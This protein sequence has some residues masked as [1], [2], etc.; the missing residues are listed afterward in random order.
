VSVRQPG[1][2]EVGYAYDEAGNR[3]AV[4]TPGGQTAYTY[5][6]AHRLV[7]LQDAAGRRTT[8]A[9][10]AEGNRTEVRYGNGVQILQSYDS[11]NR[12]AAIAHAIDGTP[13]G[14]YAYVRGPAGHIVR[15]VDGEGRQREYRYDP[16]FRLLEERTIPPGGGPAASVRYTYDA[17]G[18][19]L[20]RID[21]GGETTYAYDANDRLS[22]V[23]AG[24]GSTVLTHDANGNVVA[25]ASGGTAT[26]YEYDALNRLT[27]VVTPAG[28]ATDFT[29][30]GLDNRVRRSGP[31]GVTEFL[32]D[33][34]G[35]GGLAQVLHETDSA[36]GTT[37]YVY[38]GGLISQERE[39][40]VAY[41]L[42][43][44]HGST[45]RLTDS[46]G[47]VTDTY[48]F[49]AFGNLTG[50]T[51]TTPNAYLYTGQQ[52]DGTL[53]LYYLRARY[54]DPALGRFLTMDPAPGDLLSPETLHRY[55]Y[56]TGDPINRQDPSGRTSLSEIQAV[57]VNQ[58]I[59]ATQALPNF[60][61]VMTRFVG[62]ALTAP[63]RN[64]VT[65]ALSMIVE[66]RPLMQAAPQVVNR[67][68]LRETREVIL[69]VV[70]NSRDRCLLV[71]AMPFAIHLIPE[72][73]ANLIGSGGPVGN[74]NAMQ[75][76][77]SA[78]GTVVVIE[79]DQA[80]KQTARSIFATLQAEFCRGL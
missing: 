69:S 56:A 17:A 23:T 24:S 26:A 9:L 16:S 61:L 31:G 55:V 67:V 49:D 53:G 33:P 78:G 34:F 15:E 5:D 6:A 10:D 74:P 71:K 11:R 58:G 41:H 28:E 63:A 66:L 65:K 1:G 70:K 52:L 75:G 7:A 57:Q 46:A 12:T 18:N 19:R 47:R 44:T 54:Y 4:V 59:L 39:G 27:R 60:S 51:G 29:Y 77:S 20:S 73:A 68:V 2:A 80:A 25:R 35:A 13:I 22:T 62:Q 64:V 43:D 45:R 76:L 30:D 79:V 37:D 8:F 3:T 48:D 42:Q 72:I 38:G 40:A 32:V 14:S 36:R 21:D 50:R